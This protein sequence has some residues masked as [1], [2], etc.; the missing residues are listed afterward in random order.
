MDKI[1]QF[2]LSLGWEQFC[3]YTGLAIVAI[4]IIT[5]VIC[6]RLDRK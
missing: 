3:Y 4:I 6:E 2:I 5:D 1:Q